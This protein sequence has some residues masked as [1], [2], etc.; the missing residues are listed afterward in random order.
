M[1]TNQNTEENQLILIMHWRLQLVS[2][3]LINNHTDL[4]ITDVLSL[5]IYVK[6]SCHPETEH[7]W[8]C[9]TQ[10]E[11]HKHYVRI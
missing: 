1:C 2:C 11:A 8:M 4:C 6:Y 7:N 10:P 3:S 9:F 5:Q